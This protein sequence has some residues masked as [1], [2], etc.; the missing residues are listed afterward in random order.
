M[1]TTILLFLLP[2][3]LFGGNKSFLKDLKRSQKNAKK[4]LE[5]LDMDKAKLNA[6]KA[7][8]IIEKYNLTTR[9]LADIYIIAGVLDLTI[10]DGSKAKHY[11]K[12][13]LKLDSTSRIPTNFSSDSVEKIFLDAKEELEKDSYKILYSY[14]KSFKVTKDFPIEVQVAPLIKE[15][16]YVLTVF[17][18]TEGVNFE[19]L[20][21]KQDNK[22]F[23]GK[24]KKEQLKGTDLEVYLVLMDSN[25][26][27]QAF[28]GTEE[29]PLEINLIQSNQKESNNKAEK[30]NVLN[31]VAPSFFAF[32]IKT[33]VGAGFVTDG[34]LV[35]T[36]KNLSLDPGILLSPIWFGGDISFFISDKLLVGL[37]L[38]IQNYSS[39]DSPVW[40][41]SILSKLILLK[42]DKFKLLVGGGLGYGEVAYQV[43]ISTKDPKQKIDIVKNGSVHL[44]LESSF[45]YMLT[46]N[47]GLSSTF[48][49][50]IVAPSLSVL[51]DLNL[52]L[53]LEF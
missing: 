5:V 37:D 51:G 52:G 31:R 20:T 32:N 41:V 16:G 17:Y 24:I 18:R 39:K 4:A 14:P 27:N 9:D 22:K 30:V 46:R 11:F 21:L 19:S 45:I 42:N 1:K 26:T 43:D 35:F 10:E 3:L 50:D 36:T 44:N 15:N 40:A 34:E 38:R 29:N 7:I 8:S 53:Y 33:G 6:L 28:Y 25:L 23:I 47:F 13:A 2:L 48:R 12:K 49:L